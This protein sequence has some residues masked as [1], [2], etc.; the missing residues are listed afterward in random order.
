M[1]CAALLSMSGLAGMS[2]A[3]AQEAAPGEPAPPAPSRETNTKSNAAGVDFLV[4]TYRISRQEAEERLVVQDELS[5][6]I[7]EIA[8]QFGDRFGG[9]DIEQQAPFRVVV[10]VEGEDGATVPQSFN[11]PPR[12][13]RYIGTQRAQRSLAETNAI[14]ERL[15][16]IFRSAGNRTIV[17][18]DPAAQKFVVTAPESRIVQA[19]TRL[20]PAELFKDVTTRVG[21]LPKDSQAGYVSGDYTYGGWTLYSPSDAP[22]CTPGFVVRMSDSRNGITTAG[23]CSTATH[24]L[25]VNARRLLFAHAAMASLCMT[26]SPAFM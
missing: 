13:Q 25:W 24:K 19:L 12:L 11:L 9:I 1:V 2:S 14:V 16:T 21:L 22:I 26:M 20:I 8:A 18:F 6:K 4:N 3:F 23:H 10:L 17:N 7:E 5:E 15:A